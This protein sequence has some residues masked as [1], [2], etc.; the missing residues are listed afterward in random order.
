MSTR[1]E[2]TVAILAFILLF[3]ASQTVPGHFRRPAEKAFSDHFSN[4]PCKDIEIN[5]LHGFYPTFCQLSL[6]LNM[7]RPRRNRSGKATEPA[8]PARNEKRRCIRQV[9]QPAGKI[10]IFD[11]RHL[12][13]SGSAMKSEQVRFALR[14]AST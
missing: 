9:V 2:A 11:C 12:Y 13:G 4:N 5:A 3:P 8:G 6:A 10:P 14:S 1:P 7:T